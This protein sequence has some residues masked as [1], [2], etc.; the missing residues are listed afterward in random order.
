MKRIAI[1]AAILLGTLPASTH[2]EADPGNAVIRDAQGREIVLGGYV[3]LTE[4][5]KGNIQYTPDDYRRMV[6]MGANFQVIRATLGRLARPAGR[7]RIP[8]AAR[9]H[10]SHGPGRRTPYHFQTGH[11]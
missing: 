4:D 9:L 6:R 1:L 11:L 7:S 8:R 3:V 5:G 2:A 10:G